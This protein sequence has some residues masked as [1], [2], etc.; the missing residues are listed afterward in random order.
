M[1]VTAPAMDVGRSALTGWRKPLART[2]AG[3]LARRTRFTQEQ[4]EAAIGLA[5]FA[6]AVYRLLRP[7]VA[8]SRHPDR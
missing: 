8:A 3:P 6:F 5:L 4:I 7:V 1:E 2:V